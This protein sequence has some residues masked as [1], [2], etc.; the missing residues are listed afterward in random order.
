M[1]VDSHARVV[2]RLRAGDR[3]SVC[4]E[5]GSP[6]DADVVSVEHDRTGVCVV[7]VPTGVSWVSTRWRLRVDRTRVEWGETRFEHW[8]DGDDCWSCVGEVVELWRHSQ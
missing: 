6:F 4:I 2:A 8:L 5:R 3:V 1:A 7:L